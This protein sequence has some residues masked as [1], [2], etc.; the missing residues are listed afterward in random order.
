MN[1]ETVIA[2]VMILAV[3]FAVTAAWAIYRTLR[4]NTPHATAYLPAIVTIPVLT[5][6]IFRICGKDIHYPITLL[7]T[8][9]WDRITYALL[10]G[11]V[12][13]I[14]SGLLRR[15]SLES[16]HMMHTWQTK[17]FCSFF[18]GNGI[19]AIPLL[20]TLAY[21]YALAKSWQLQLPLLFTELVIVECLFNAPGLGYELWQGVLKHNFA[22]VSLVLMY[23]LVLYALAYGSSF[24]ISR[25]LALK[26]KGYD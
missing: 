21:R 14:S 13:A 16:A 5:I 2:S 9:H 22:A 12:L 11:F 1:L 20:R 8:S 10:P 17:S 4:K 23:F 15:I 19:A 18:A 25:Q 6:A 24:W 3:T 7:T 26:L